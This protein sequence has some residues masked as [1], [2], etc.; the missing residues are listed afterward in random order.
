MWN[1]GE[2]RLK[3]AYGSTGCYER[4]VHTCTVRGLAFSALPMQ[5]LWCLK[6]THQ[7]LRFFCTWWWFP[8][9]CSA[10]RV[11]TCVSTALVSCFLL[12]RRFDL[13]DRVFV[14]C[15]TTCSW[16]P[17]ARFSVV[18][19]SGGASGHGVRFAG[20]VTSKGGS[21]THLSHVQTNINSNAEE[22]KSLIGKQK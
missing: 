18:G 11:E 3:S 10:C 21:I 9:F 15:F 5:I 7:L 14:E 4:S 8:Q 20:T 2:I 17:I 13:G 22:R 16:I 12:L 6:F 19:S 1:F